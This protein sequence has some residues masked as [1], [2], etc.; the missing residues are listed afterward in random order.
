MPGCNRR[1]KRKYTLKEHIKTHSGFKPFICPVRTCRKRF[2]TSGN[3]TRHKR[4]H[5]WLDQPIECLVNGCGCVFSDE[6]KLERHMATHFDGSS[7][8]R[9]AVS[10]C[11]DDDG[12]GDGDLERLH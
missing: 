1:F 12:D 5:P 9:C 6:T 10:S 2:T 4:Q 3:L 7:P 8:H 11:D